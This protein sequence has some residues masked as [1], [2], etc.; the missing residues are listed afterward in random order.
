[1]HR[2][3]EECGNEFGVSLEV[4]KKMNNDVIDKLYLLIANNKS[5]KHQI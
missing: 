4:V 2:A 5:K 1:M 3:L